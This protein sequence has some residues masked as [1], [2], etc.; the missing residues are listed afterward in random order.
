MNCPQQNCEVL[1]DETCVLLHDLIGNFCSFFLDSRLRRND[2]EY[3]IVTLKKA[4][5]NSIV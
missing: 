3:S 5:R 4:S 1:D 2:V